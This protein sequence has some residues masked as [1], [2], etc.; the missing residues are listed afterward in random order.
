MEDNVPYNQLV[1][2][3]T[4]PS[5]PL[6]GGS[7]AYI[8]VELSLAMII[9]L[10]KIKLK[11]PSD[12]SPFYENTIL[13]CSSVM[14]F[15]HEMITKDGEIFASLRGT[16]IATE[17]DEIIEG[18]FPKSLAFLSNL[19]LINSFLDTLIENTTSSLKNDYIMLKTNLIGSFTNL[20]SILKF[21]VNKMADL[22]K[23]DE[24]INQIDDIIMKQRLQDNKGDN[25]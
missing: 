3:L 12:S 17:K 15:A 4:D 14:P 10:M 18:I 20:A 1:K 23:R 24:H 21:E 7:L 5:D 22:T 19:T 9:K 8:N 16:S 2:N 6:F 25:Q 13:I 11:K